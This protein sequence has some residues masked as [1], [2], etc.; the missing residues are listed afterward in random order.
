MDLHT[1]AL[2]LLRWLLAQQEV[3]ADHASRKTE[4]S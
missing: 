2:S 4:A 1:T 3:I